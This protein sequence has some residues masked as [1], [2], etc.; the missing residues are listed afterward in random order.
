M[1][2]SDLHRETEEILSNRRRVFVP[3]PRMNPDEGKTFNEESSKAV[4]DFNA[5][6]ISFSEMWS[7][8]RKNALKDFPVEK[9]EKFPKKGDLV[10]YEGKTKPNGVISWASRSED[11]V[12]VYFFD[13]GIETYSLDF[14][15]NYTHARGRRLWLLQ[16]VV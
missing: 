9:E 15:G 3:P 10:H 11:V 1:S 12:G 16:D 6:L 8:L 4:L 13:A 5:G 7:V 14:F 2:V